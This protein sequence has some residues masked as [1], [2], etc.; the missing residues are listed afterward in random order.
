MDRL[1]KNS[2]EVFGKVLIAR[3]DTI[4]FVFK[5][6]KYLILLL[7]VSVAQDCVSVYLLEMLARSP[8]DFQFDV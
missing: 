7:C 6:N 2:I 5:C 8:G 4:D 1:V 3:N